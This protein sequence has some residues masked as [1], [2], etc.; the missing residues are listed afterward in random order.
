[1]RN[2][3]LREETGRVLGVGAALWGSVV[4]I[5]ALEGAFA[6]FDTASIAFAAAF[7]ALF[8]VA[9]YLL[10]PQLREYAVGMQAPRVIALGLAAAFIVSISLGSAPFATFLAPLAALAGVAAATQRRAV[11]SASPAKSPGARP[12]GI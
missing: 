4:G 9:S 12:A 3:K 6:R 2:Q 1:M 7:V 11:R 8:A 10:D 5:A